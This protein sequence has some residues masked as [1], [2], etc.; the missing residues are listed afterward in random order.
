MKK[1]LSI[2]FLSIFLMMF[3]AQ[4]QVDCCFSLS[5]PA[6]DTLHNIANLPNGDL[7]LTHTMS[8]PSYGGTS[9]YDLVFSDA[10]CLGIDP[11]TGK[12]SIELEL[13]CDGENILDGQHDLS[14]YC[15]I[16]LQTYYNELHWVGTPMLGQNYPYA[17][18]Y[19]G[20]VPIFSGTYNIS[21]IAFDYFYFKF[22]INTQTRLQITW[23]QVFRDVQLIVHIRERIHGTDNELYWDAQQR[24]NLGGH[25]SQ[26]RDI[27]ASD[28]LSTTPVTMLNDTIKDCEP[29][30]VGMP[31]YTMDT[32]GVYNIAY[33]DTSCGYRI[34]SVVTYD[35]THYV[36][37]TTPTLSDSTIRYCQ[38]GDATPLTLDAE[39]NPALA[40]H[41]ADIV[42]YWY[43]AAEDS[44]Y[45]AASFT[46]V[47]DTT[48]GDYYYYVKRH[49]NVTGCESEIDTFKVTINPN[50]A[51]PVVTDTLV[52]YCVGETAVALSYP[53]PTGQQVLWGT[54]ATDI[55][56]TTAPVPAT[57]AAD[58][59]I[60]YLKL[61]DT[62]TVNNCISE[63]YD[64]ITVV[65]YANPTVT[66]TN[67][68]DTLCFGDVA[69]MTA[70]PT[71]L[72]T[73]QWKKD[74]V[75]VTDSTNTHFS[76][77]NDVTDTTVF[78]FSV[79]VT[80][81]HVVKSCSALDSVEVLA[82]PEIGA[83]TVVR[84]DTAICGPG[85]VTREV[86]NGTHA[87]TSKWYAS[88]K[89]T[90]LGTG[91]TY[92][93]NFTVT[94][95]LYVS[96]LNDFGCETPV[97]NWTRIIVRVDS[98]PQI[99]L[100]TDHAGDSVCAEEDLIIRSSVVP[101]GVALTYLWSGTGLV[102][103]LNEDSV[104]FN[105]ATAG[106]YTDTLKVTITSTGCF[107]HATID[108][109]VDTLPVI[110][111]DVNYTVDNST[112]CVGANGKIEF[113]TPDYIRYS[114]DSAMTW[115]TTKVFDTLAAGNYY[116][117]VEDGRGCKNHANLETIIKDTINPTLTI[118]DSANVRCEAEFNGQLIVSVAPAA[119]AGVHA[120]QYQLNDGAAQL[121]SV[122][123][124]LE[125]GNTY[126]ITVTDTITGCK[127]DS[128][129][130]VVTDGRVT[131]VLTL[132]QNPNTHCT[133]PYGGSIA[134]TAMN[135]SEPVYQYRIVKN[136]I[137]TSAY[138]FDTLFTE[139]L[140]GFYTVIAQD[141]ATACLGSDTISVQYT[142]VL[143]TATI[144]ALQEI[145]YGDTNQVSLIGGDTSVVFDYWTYAG[146][147]PATDPMVDTIL[148][149]QSFS[150]KG[151]PAGK[152]TFM[153]H[154]HDTITHCPSTVTDTLRVI[155]VNIDLL[156][157]PYDAHV[158][159]YDSVKVFCRY[160]PDD[161]ED[162]IVLYNWYANEYHYVA[163]GVYDT[164]WVTPTYENKRVSIVTYDN[165]GCSS[166][167]YVDL[168][169]WPLPALTINVD[170][171]NYCENSTSNIHVTPSSTPTYT[172]AWKKDGVVL[173]GQTT[174]LLAIN[175]GTADFNVTVTVTDGHSCVSDSTFLV[176]V[177][178]T[179]GAPV[180]SPDTQ[181][182]CDNDVHVDTTVQLAPQIGTFNWLTPSANV[183]KQTGKYIANYVNTENGVSCY[184]ANDTVEVIVTG[185]PVF[186]VEEKYNSETAVDTAHVRCFE[187]G[188][189]D[190]LHITV[191]PAASATLTY[192]YKLNGVDT[193]AN[194]II[195]RTEP[196]TYVDTIYI[197]ATAQHAA[198]TCYYDTTFYYTLKINALPTAPVNFPNSYNGG[199]S[200][201]FYCQGSTATY[202]FTLGENQIATYNG[203]TT[204]PTTAYDN[205]AM[206]ITDTMTH[207]SNTFYYDIVE[208]ATPTVKLTS[209]LADDCSDTLR[210]K[211]IATVT[212]AYDAT[213]ERVYTW[214]PA[215]V[216]PASPHHK[217]V[218]TD[219]VTY[220]FRAPN[221]TIVTANVTI[222]VSNGAYSASCVSA[223]S[224][225]IVTFQPAPDKP[226]M[227]TSV[228]GYVTLDSIA[229]CDGSTF[230]ITAADFTTSTGATINMVDG[231]I[232]ESTAIDTIY[233]VVANN[234]DA[235]YCP[236][237]TLYVKV[238]QKRMPA[239]PVFDTVYYCAGTPATYTIT[240]L[241]A[242]DTITYYK[243]TELLSA[244]PDTA[245]NFIM[246]IEDKIEGC[247]RDTTLVIVEVALPTA[248]I[249][250]STN[251]H[252]DTICE[253]G[254]ID[255]TYVFSI[256][257]HVQH[258]AIETFTW[259]DITSTTNTAH[260]S[261]TP[262][263]DTSVTFFYH[264]IDTVANSFSHIAC[265]YNFDSTITYI[266][267]AKPAVPYYFGDTLFCA[268]DSIVIGVDS[269][270]LATTSTELYSTITL[271]VTYKTTPSI[272][273]FDVQSQY[274]YYPS[275]KSTV[276][277]IMI[278]GYDLPNLS[279]AKTKDQI[280]FEGDTSTFTASS[281]TP[282]TY[283]VWGTTDTIASI[284][285]AD[286]VMHYVQ[287]IEDH[288]CV[289][290]DSAKVTYYPLFTV[291]LSNDTTVCIGV[292]VDLSATVTGSTEPFTLYWYKDSV[293]TD[294]LKFTDSAVPSGVAQTHNF[295][296]DSSAIVNG[297]PVPNKYMIKVEDNYGC[298]MSA[299][300]NV[301][302]V[303][304][305]NRP[306]FTFHEIDSTK[307]IHEMKVK[308]GDQAGFEMIINQN[309]GD[310]AE[311]VFVAVQIYKDGVPMTT[312]E[313]G[314]A[315]DYIISSY[316]TSYEFDVNHTNAPALESVGI[317]ACNFGEASY[318]FPNSEFINYNHYNYD[319]LYMH[320]LDGRKITVRT[321]AFKADAVGD[322]TFSFA[323]IKAGPHTAEVGQLYIGSKKVGGYNGHVGLTV[324]DT[325][326]FDTFTIHVDSSNV[327]GADNLV[328]ATVTTTPDEDVNA[329]AI[330][331][332]VYPNPASNNVN[333]VMTGVKGQ[334]V[335]TV[336]D[337]SGKAVASMKVDV[338]E[339][340][341][342]INLPVGN[343]SQGIYFIKA[344]NGSAVMTKKLIIAR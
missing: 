154:F 104:T 50:P 180:F 35:Y 338:D 4:A 31:A 122:F 280:C 124:K 287:A 36:H 301:I 155:D 334:T 91:T 281:T 118:T 9:T 260:L 66:I 53:A 8:V 11:A 317:K 14:R 2:C 321:G 232:T 293:S 223:D 249:S 98:V 204:A 225:F 63:D 52:E 221:D 37:P 82:Y 251:W 245:G 137:D 187:P 156:T 76:Y 271:P 109:T 48:A 218:N 172:Y 144:S 29:V 77:T 7:P 38:K 176:N 188:A 136:L 329:E 167:K 340:N 42:P 343:F 257:P 283:F 259:K 214:T 100:T 138:Q 202:S 294:S 253:G 233:R 143:P 277:T 61:Q 337:M 13:W 64:S 278:Y 265:A 292:S 102:A 84:G 307:D 297:V 108:I 96:S 186:T 57:T 24:E 92:T 284:N 235:P 228:A 51:A 248:T 194:M 275:C 69:S 74:G 15:N 81:L 157:I 121:D 22:L 195:T 3:S 208:V 97:A 128:L 274:T 105:Y 149:K 111:K 310:Q 116:L 40:D 288:G 151:F 268:G 75:D 316:N 30:T 6:A 58:T 305:T 238:H 332:N 39:P 129:N 60:Y 185:A 179:P 298:V 262:T 289:N 93:Q 26:P 227:S 130:Q 207:C 1:L 173:T 27:L 290:N 65:V 229:Y 163:P 330:N 325:V 263:A 120:Y 150:L 171:Q 107:N 247:G 46:P 222:N 140:H 123:T 23:N 152:H 242:N 224:S 314:S 230:T 86:A 217:Y 216:D 165:H 206:V 95:T 125:N 106:T 21:N 226:V 20:A 183:E 286:T 139:L 190:T 87:S 197:K 272:N 62:T 132:T 174:S 32:T 43:F 141:T 161:A 49:D 114:I 168:N 67:D 201:I 70:A 304:A 341:Q 269:F 71:T 282:N 178:P 133:T 244:Q 127:T 273:T 99:T 342:I 101:T 261:A 234:N 291:A 45:Y 112:F 191:N 246:H 78:T 309:C 131:P 47:T 299:E 33:V 215:S 306:G 160:F 199:D 196:G 170:E 175:V 200:T 162:S 209:D 145:C 68:N 279:V 34:D 115:R 211:V 117:V 344:V 56:S 182:F 336:H 18:E 113:T 241:N 193:S 302:N 256:T 210:G 328:N 212:P 110:V 320:F 219:T 189:G 54:T 270:S 134:V 94:D 90:E 55:T 88:D 85:T 258:S 319:W 153:G 28:T 339:N 323:V 19:P 205:V 315:M 146:P 300:S 324:L 59:T 322:Y 10:N 240:K 250:S 72:T 25:Q 184:S 264:L 17:Y 192:S 169:V 313:M 41:V 142:M 73:Y 159:S 327:S 311:R 119:E 308:C 237:D 5:N 303:A 12:V 312:A 318:F 331:M 203:A 158:C 255:E 80:E 267:L 148:G 266:Y 181:Y 198:T 326:A 276:N 335:I 239:V 83:P 254:S 236:S 166:S 126:K 135:P 295:T 103:P 296:P 177:I 213:Y 44:F 164:L 285:V 231:N 252:N 79:A 147:V 89:T 16:T 243:G 220:T 333:V